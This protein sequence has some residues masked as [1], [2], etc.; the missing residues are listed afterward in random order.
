MQKHDLHYE[1]PQFAEKIFV[2]Q[3]T[4]HY[5]KKLCDQYQDVNNSITG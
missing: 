2:M 3:R 4:D 1:F 5:F